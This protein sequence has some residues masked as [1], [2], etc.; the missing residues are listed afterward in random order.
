[1]ADVSN[2]Y[3]LNVLQK[4]KQVKIRFFI[5]KECRKATLLT[6]FIVVS[7]IVLLGYLMLI[8]VYRFLTVNKTVDTK[9]MVIEGWVDDNVLDEALDYYRKNGFNKLIVTGLPVT[10][11]RLFSYFKNTAQLAA[12]QIKNSGFTDTVYQAVIPK[13]ILIDRTFNTAIAVKILFDE[14][15]G[16]E[17]SFLIYSEGTHSRRTKLMFDKVFGDDFSIGI[18]AGNEKIF[19]SKHF[20]RTSKGFRT[21]TNEFVAY[22]WVYLFFHPDIDESVKKFKELKMS[23][24]PE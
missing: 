1:M 8:N 14:H 23:E 3:C 2:S 24:N 20:W 19:D 17:K 4:N 9:T 11:R 10:K 18:I 16:W 22:L 21:V 7:G 12:A 5:K 6:R 15:P 13:G